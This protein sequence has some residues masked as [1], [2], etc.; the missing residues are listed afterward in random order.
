MISEKNKLDFNEKFTEAYDLMETSSK[1][2]FVTGKAGT[3]KSTLL[4]YFRDKT[5]KNIAVLA[6]TGVAAVNIKGQTIHSFFMFKPDITPESVSNIKIRKT[7]RVIYKEIEVIVIDEISMVRADLLDC[8][9]TFMRL[10]G[11]KKDLSF[12]GVQM[13]FIGDLYQLPPVV[14]KLDEKIFRD[15]YKSPYF[16]DAK[17]FESFDMDLVELEKV[18]RQKDAEYLDILNSIRNKTITSGNLEILNKRFFMNVNMDNTDFYIYLTTTN[19]MADNINQEKLS[20]LRT[21]SFNYQGHI[22]GSFELKNLPTYQRL[23]LKI[24]AQV[25]L[26]NND[27]AGRWVNGTIGQVAAF[28]QNEKAEDIVNVKLLDGKLVEV[29]PFSWEMFKFS[30]NE[31]LS[32]I[33]SESVGSFSQYP[34]KLAWA[35]TIHKSQG[36]TFPKVILDIGRGTF[37]H[38]QVYVALSRCISSEGL[39]LK[40]KIEK[41]HILLDWRVLE[42]NMKNKCKIS[43][44]ICPLDEKKQIISDAISRGDEVDIV[45]VNSKD[46]KCQRVIRP[47]YLGEMN[48]FG[49][50]YLGVEG[51]CCLKG[52]NRSFRLDRI[53]AIREKDTGKTFGMW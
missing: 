34:L 32:K 50:N 22:S 51:Y 19:K 37:S 26:L 36:K 39:I 3:G 24:G 5:F 43:E 9:D 18:Y 52:Q 27:S 14:T 38:G 10:Y 28:N 46:Q 17:V 41:K 44:K 48:Y 42:F 35:V 45:Y 47:K 6:P 21:K 1:N 31:T 16:F 12:G 20:K 4:Q 13:V 33:E 49:K 53:L 7:K 8:V 15:V 2:I 25:M 30:Y 29:T 23:N 11:P 40:Q